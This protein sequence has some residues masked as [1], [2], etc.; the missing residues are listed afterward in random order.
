MVSSISSS[1]IS[2]QTLK[3]LGINSKQLNQNIAALASGNR[4]TSASTDVAALSVATGM[5]SEVSS[6]RTASQNINEA[7]SLMQVADGGLSQTSLMLDRMRAIATQAT[8]GSLGQA[9]REGLNTEFQSLAKEID[10][11]AST[12]QFS[13]VKLLD[14]SLSGDD[15]ASFQ[16]GSSTEDSVK[17]AIGDVSTASIFSGGTPNLLT[18]D[19]SAK[20]LSSVRSAMDYVTT[21]RANLGSSQEALAYTGANVDV[22]IQNQEAA[23]A[24]LA[25]TDF[26][27]TSTE[28]A[29][30]EV[31][32]KAGIATLAQGNRMS[33]NLLRLV[34]G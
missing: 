25:D 16:V 23:R 9:A 3:L 29:I 24:T 30:L 27:G 17:L 20:A 6:L 19:S 22:A 14:G 13:G 5:Q 18:A 33:S 12:T 8:N 10:R 15:A 7:S 11:V 31:R 2:A 28:N 1:G 26:L 34:G 21:Q 32:N 4:L